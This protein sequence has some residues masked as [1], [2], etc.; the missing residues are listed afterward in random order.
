MFEN[1][2]CCKEL[3][4]IADELGIKAYSVEQEQTAPIGAV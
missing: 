1:V 2:V 3:P 4:N